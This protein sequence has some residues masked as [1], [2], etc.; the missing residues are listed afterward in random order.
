MKSGKALDKRKVAILK[1]LKKIFISRRNSDFHKKKF[2]LPAEG[3]STSKSFTVLH[4]SS[5][6]KKYK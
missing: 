2:R 4:N 6:S 3:F 1:Y 5:F